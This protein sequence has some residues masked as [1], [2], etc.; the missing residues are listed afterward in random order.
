MFNVWVDY[1]TLEEEQR[2]LSQTT[3]RES[4]PRRIVLSD[5]QLLN[6]QKLIATIPVTQYIIDYAA[7]LV[8]ASRPDNPSAPDFIGKFV[9]WGAGPRAGQGLIWAG[10]AFA[11]REGPNCG[12]RFAGEANTKLLTQAFHWAFE[13][14]NSQPL[15]A[16]S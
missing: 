8:R 1:P 2:I 9:D 14:D 13:G 16:D 15:K 11:A 10:K 3:G 6:M 5:R 12:H 7:R 4:P